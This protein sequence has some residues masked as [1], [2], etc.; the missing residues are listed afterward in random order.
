MKEKKSSHKKSL[1]CISCAKEGVFSWMLFG[2]GVATKVALGWSVTL[3]ACF[4]I[5]EGKV[6]EF[7]FLGNPFGRQVP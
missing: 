7:P 3:A 5:V 1:Y 4:S 6:R 2:N